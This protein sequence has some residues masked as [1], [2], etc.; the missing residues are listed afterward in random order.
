MNSTSSHI[1]LNAKQANTNW[2]THSH[3]TTPYSVFDHFVGV[4]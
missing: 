2:L 4:Y 1:V 3:Q